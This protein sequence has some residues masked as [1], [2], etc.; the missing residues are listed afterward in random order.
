MGAVNK[1]REASSARA[2]GSFLRPVQK[3]DGKAA[4]DGISGALW[5]CSPGGDAAPSQKLRALRGPLRKWAMALVSFL[6]LSGGWGALSSRLLPG[7]V[8]KHTAAAQPWGAVRR[9]QHTG[10]SGS[11][12]VLIPAPPSSGPL[13]RAA[14]FVEN[15]DL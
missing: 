13:G 12:Q 11:G 2:Q 6:Q 1:E 4:Y 10:P 7:H 5:G 9:G 14:L 8:C 15:K 3:E